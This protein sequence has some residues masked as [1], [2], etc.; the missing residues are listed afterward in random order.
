MQCSEHWCL[1]S[2]VARWGPGGWAWEVSCSHAIVP[3]PKRE[4]SSAPGSA[5][6]V[7][8][9]LATFPAFSGECCAYLYSL[10][11]ILPCFWQICVTWMPPV[12]NYT[13]LCPFGGHIASEFTVYVFSA[14]VGCFFFAVLPLKLVLPVSQGCIQIVACNAHWRVVHNFCFYPVLN[15]H[16]A[17]LT[18]ICLYATMLFL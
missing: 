4:G 7:F 13:C 18:I 9:C 16:K 6:P 14:Y 10:V 15:T 8:F 17:S 2:L 3:L 5:Y 12:S 1:R 11:L